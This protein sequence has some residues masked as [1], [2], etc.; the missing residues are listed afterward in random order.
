MRRAEKS[1]EEVGSGESRGEEWKGAAR[2][3]DEV[4]RLV[5]PRREEMKKTR[6]RVVTM[7]KSRDL[8]GAAK[9]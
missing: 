7:E 5:E 8:R 9:S 1:L 4:K 6:D 3:G 2:S